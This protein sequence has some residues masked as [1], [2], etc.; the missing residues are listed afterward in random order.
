MENGSDWLL[1]G[2]GVTRGGSLIDKPMVPHLPSKLHF[3]KNTVS[4]PSVLAVKRDKRLR[5][6][7]NL[8]WLMDVDMYKRLWDELGEPT[9]VSDTLIANY[10]NGDQVSASG[11][12]IHILHEL[13]Y[14]WKKHGENSSISGKL[15]YLKRKAKSEISKILPFSR[16][17]SED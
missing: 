14:V 16:T 15:E 5:F 7:E 4:S 11:S 17:I 8:T 2:S 1:S 12:K 13:D 9:I 6:D 3:G 10:L